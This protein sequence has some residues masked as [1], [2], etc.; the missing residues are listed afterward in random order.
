VGPGA[1]HNP[2]VDD[3]DR[4]RLNRTWWDERVPIHLAGEF[5]DIGGLLAGG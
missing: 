1:H 4:I 5:Y 3:E 2:G